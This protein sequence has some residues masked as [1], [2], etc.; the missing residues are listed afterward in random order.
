MVRRIPVPPGS[1][2][3]KERGVDEVTYVE[4]ALTF[5]VPTTRIVI[6][7]GTTVIV[8]AYALF[9]SFASATEFSRSAATE[10]V[11]VPGVEGDVHEA[12]NGPATSSARIG[13]SDTREKGADGVE[14][15]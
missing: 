9:V 13:G 7:L 10:T 5:G 14:S 8:H 12:T 1:E 11:N 4:A 15:L 3:C 2:M 6:G